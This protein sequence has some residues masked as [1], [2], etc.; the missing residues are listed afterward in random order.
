VIESAE[1]VVPGGGGMPSAAAIANLR[2]AE[3]A[4]FLAQQ[5]LMTFISGSERFTPDG[6]AEHRHL[7]DNVMQKTT[8]YMDAFRAACNS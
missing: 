3:K 5:E 1:T 7:A 6:I 2:L 8:E 4:M